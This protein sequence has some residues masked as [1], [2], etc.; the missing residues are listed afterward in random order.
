MKPERGEGENEYELGGN[1][2]T[3]VKEWPVAA[4]EEQR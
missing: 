2:N 1:Q 3:V 4:W